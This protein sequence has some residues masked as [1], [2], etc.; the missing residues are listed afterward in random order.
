MPSK[1]ILRILIVAEFILLIGA[2]IIAVITEGS[3]PEPLR[4]YEAAHDSLDSADIIMGIFLLVVFAVSR[5]GLIVLWRPARELYV[6]SMVAATF[7]TC[8]A[9]AIVHTGLEDALV[10]SGLIV[11][12]VVSALIYWSPLSDL[13]C[14]KQPQAPPP[15]NSPA[16]PLAQSRKKAIVSAISFAVIGLLVTLVVK[17]LGLLYI[18]LFLRR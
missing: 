12:G 17:A 13:Y 2:P 5:I 15:A 7:Y 9:R 3:L 11:F 16:T 10:S 1:A 14:A 18:Q 8:F 6:W 4:T